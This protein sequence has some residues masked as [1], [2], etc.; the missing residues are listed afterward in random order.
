MGCTPT[1]HPW[2]HHHPR[3]LHGVSLA[4]QFKLPEL[5]MLQTRLQAKFLQRG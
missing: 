4:I 1:T 5:T 2:L 3:H